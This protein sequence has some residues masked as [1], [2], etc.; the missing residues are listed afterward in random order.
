[1]LYYHLYDFDKI[2]SQVSVDSIQDQ[3]VGVIFDLKSLIKVLTDLICETASIPVKHPG[4]LTS[5]S[6]V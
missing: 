3:N 1:M 2:S 4:A 5:T 6:E